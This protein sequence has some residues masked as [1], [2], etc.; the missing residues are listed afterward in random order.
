MVFPKLVDILN[1]AIAFSFLQPDKNLVC[2]A[3]N[4][5]HE[6]NLRYTLLDICLVNS[7]GVYP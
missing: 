3:V 5:A 4:I 2:L 6:S 1:E 7:D